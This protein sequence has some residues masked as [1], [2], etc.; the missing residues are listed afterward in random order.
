MENTLFENASGPPPSASPSKTVLGWLALAAA[1]LSVSACGL[2]IIVGV[3]GEF[4]G[5]DAKHGLNIAAGLV[6]F[7]G[8]FLALLG[9]VFGV[10]GMLGPGERRI[11][12]V[13]GTVV[14]VCLLLVSVAILLLGF[15]AQLHES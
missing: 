13:I 1:L 11:H 5:V 6:W 9:V 4:A 2:A 3:A 10:L 14:C 8:M 7:G 15:I 12:A